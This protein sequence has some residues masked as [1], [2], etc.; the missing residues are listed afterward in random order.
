[1]PGKLEISFIHV[2]KVE[3]EITRE[4]VLLRIYDPVKIM[5]VTRKIL[6]VSYPSTISK[7]NNI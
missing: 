1:M 6:E 5:T 3:G 2:E 4:I 7:N